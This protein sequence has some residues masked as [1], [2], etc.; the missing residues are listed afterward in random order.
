MEFDVLQFINL[1]IIV[2]FFLV[3]YKGL[4]YDKVS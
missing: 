2:D 3:N 4:S 1:S